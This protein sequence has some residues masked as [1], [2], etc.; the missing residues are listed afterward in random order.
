M[1]LLIFTDRMQSDKGQVSTA[2]YLNGY[3]SEYGHSVNEYPLSDF[4]GTHDEVTFLIKK[5]KNYD[6]L[7]YSIWSVNTIKTHLKLLLT[8][9][10]QLNKPIVLGGPAMPELYNN[11]ILSKLTSIFDFMIVGSGEY[12]INELMLNQNIESLSFEDKISPSKFKPTQYLKKKYSEI[13]EKTFVSIPIRTFDKCYKP[14]CFFCTFNNSYYLSSKG[15]LDVEW[16]NV[17]KTMNNIVLE[18]NNIHLTE[19]RI[20]FNM[21]HASIDEANLQLLLCNLNLYKE[22]N[23]EWLS[24]IR[25]EKWV[26]KHLPK[27][28]FLNGMLDVG[29]E[30]LSNKN[31]VVNK[32][33]KTY[34]Q[35]EF[36]IKCKENN[37]PL[38]ATFMY[39]LPKT[40]KQDMIE[41]LINIARIR[42][43]FSYF[44]LNQFF[45][46]DG[47][48]YSK[49]PDKFDIE[50]CNNN[51]HSFC[52]YSGFKLKNN[53]NHW[54]N[55]NKKYAL[56]FADI[57]EMQLVSYQRPLRGFVALSKI[58]LPILRG[59]M[60]KFFPD[61]LYLIENTISSIW[62]LK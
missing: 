58:E 62:K 34:D 25:A 42:H 8:L 44:V 36:A 9:K 33:I 22:G 49:M 15:L 56:A 13:A 52:S 35:V 53:H 50:F 17:V 29:F 30:F 1:K 45:M 16:K 57:M 59:I 2:S 55:L 39:G 37:V 26:I 7:G 18:L 46:E 40:D 61:D 10:K 19:S 21:S 27:I 60:H 3:I 48:T 51:S 31:D 5:S 23:Y 12:L 20:Y 24:F 54:V 43:T 11:N 32:G 47:S 41:S 6:Y 14:S 4:K 28:A 38:W